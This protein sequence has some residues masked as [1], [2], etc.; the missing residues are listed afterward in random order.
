M[1]YDDVFMIH[2]YMMGL[3]FFLMGLWMVKN[4]GC[5]YCF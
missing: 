3:C 5:S 4:D 2:D 1:K